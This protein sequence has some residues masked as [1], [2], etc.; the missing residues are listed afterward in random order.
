M[1]DERSPKNNLNEKNLTDR[2]V[3]KPPKEILKERSSSTC[4]NEVNFIER[5]KTKILPQSKIKK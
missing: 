1:F 3:I 2:E 5:N 4:S